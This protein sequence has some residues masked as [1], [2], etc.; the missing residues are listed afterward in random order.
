ML[1][2]YRAVPNINA[3]AFI[4]DLLAYVLTSDQA[5]LPLR[6][7]VIGRQVYF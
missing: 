2:L 3:K 6:N 4:V 1:L 5:S 7:P